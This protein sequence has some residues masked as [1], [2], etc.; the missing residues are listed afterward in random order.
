V[1]LTQPPLQW[2]PLSG[3]IVELSLDLK[4][5]AASLRPKRRQPGKPVAKYMD[6]HR[7][8]LIGSLSII[9]GVLVTLGVTPTTCTAQGQFEKSIKQMMT[10][11]EFSAA[12]LDKLSSEQLEKLDAWLQGYRQSTEKKASE[13]AEKK[14]SE[15]TART[16]LDMLVSRVDGTFEG[17]KGR[18]IIRLEDGTAWKQ[19]NSE[20]LFRSSV[21]DHPGAV[22]SH[23]IFGYKMRIEGT[24][25]FYVDP[26]RNP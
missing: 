18:T 13:V 25:E 15:R 2:Q 1:R 9:L 3:E 21:T 6:A 26:V 20:D 22:V 23:T 7:C 8:G 12:G 11:E 17:L 24:P 16:K 14:A 19:A 10:P 4:I 5:A